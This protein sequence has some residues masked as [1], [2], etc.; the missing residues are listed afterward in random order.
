MTYR[1]FKSIWQSV[2]LAGFLLWGL[3]ATSCNEKEETV[4]DNYVTTESVAI[5]DFSLSPDLR[6]M[7]NLDS[8]YFSIDLE[9]GIVFNADSLPK[10]TNVTKLIP[11]ISYPSTVTSAVIEMTGGTHREGTS[12][13]YSNANDTIDFTGDVKLTLGAANK[14]ITKTYTLKVNVHKE[15]P[16]TMYWES[17]ASSLLP[18]RLSDPVRQK[19]VTFNSGVFSMIEE[20]DG[21][22]TVANTADI[23]S[24]VWEKKELKSDFTPV[25]ES[26]TSSRG[27]LY[28]IGNGNLMKSSDGS[29]WEIAAEGWEA[30]IGEYGTKVLGRKEMSTVSFPGDQYAGISLPEAFPVSGYSEPVQLVSRWDSDPMIIIFGGVSSS[31]ALSSASWA[32]DGNEWVNI[33]DRPLPALDGLSV[34]KY[35]S[36]LNSA[37]NGLLKEF[38][39]YFAFGGRNANG[40]INNTIYITYD[41]GI[42]WQKAQ[43]YFG[44]PSGM[45]AGYNVNALTLGTSM[46]SSLSDRWKAKRHLP[47]EVEGDIIKWDCPYIFLFGGYNNNMKLYDTI[48][49]G[50]LQRLTFVPLF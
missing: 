4:N 2:L 44:L 13:Y 20:S 41:H 27:S 11:K 16:D 30:I 43:E 24:G 21:T 33:A 22:F 47:F 6:I 45:E 29:S 50:V 8:V 32:F 10:G 14:S 39:A 9:H 3:V 46:E 38:E 37:S 42:T 40:D 25:I 5:T 12:N 23:F 26:L 36:Y 34:V 17:T 31:G 49:S 28:V 48:R 7:K 1:Y 35:Y 18:S 15:D 19:S